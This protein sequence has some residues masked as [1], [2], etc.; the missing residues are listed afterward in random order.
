M[1]RWLYL[2]ALAYKLAR[3]SCTYAPASHVIPWVSC[4]CVRQGKASSGCQLSWQS[5]HWACHTEALNWWLRLRRGKASSR[6]QTASKQ[7]AG[8]KG[9]KARRNTLDAAQLAAAQAATDLL[10]R[11]RRAS[12]SAAQPAA[13]PA[14]A[15]PAAAAAE[16]PAAGELCVRSYTPRLVQRL[17]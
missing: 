17:K 9:G 15:P 7:V 3:N 16:E 13:A 1:P 8:A 5:A 6:S 2:L 11:R 4:T 10:P 12:A 14:E